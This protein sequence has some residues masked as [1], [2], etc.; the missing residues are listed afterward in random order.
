MPQYIRPKKWP[1]DH[2]KE[3]YK[4]GYYIEAI[5]VLHGW[6]EVKLRELLISLRAEA[7]GHDRHF[8]HIWDMTNDIS[9]L[10]AAKALFIAGVISEA[11][12]S[13]IQAFNRVRNNL[14][15]KFFFDPYEKPYPGIPKREY[16]AALHAGDRLGW[17]LQELAD[18][19]FELS[20]SSNSPVK[21]V[22]NKSRK[23]T[24]AASNQT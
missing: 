18:K 6:I 11:Q 5:Q 13:R 12:Y 24:E 15:H 3:A 23:S 21:K 10:N 4:A 22:R 7:A 16:R 19:R 2:A 8:A 9:L 20:A 17:T 14:I 1:M